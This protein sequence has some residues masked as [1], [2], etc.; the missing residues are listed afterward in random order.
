MTAAAVTAISGEVGETKDPWDLVDAARAGDDTAFCRLYAE[1]VAA[2]F[3][4]VVARTRDESLAEDLTSETFLRAYTGIHSLTYRGRSVR[5]WIL[6][7]AR[8]LV[9]DNARSARSRYEVALLDEYDLAAH[10][11]DPAATVCSRLESADIWRMV[12]ELPADQRR[13]VRLR[14]Y[15][16]RSVSEVA[17]LLR[18]TEGSIRALQCRAIRRLAAAVPVATAA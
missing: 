7:I 3:S 2:V 1:N 14:F 8:N 6:T 9:L 4:L 16:Q 18:R 15:E 12:D 13:C 5:G 11:E 10:A 17:V